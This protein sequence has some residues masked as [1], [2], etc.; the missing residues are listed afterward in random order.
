[1]RESRDMFQN[2][3]AELMRTVKG[4]QAKLKKLD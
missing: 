2:R 1:L 4:L 3:N